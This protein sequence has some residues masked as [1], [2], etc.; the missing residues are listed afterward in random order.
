M[1]HNEFLPFSAESVRQNA[2]LS[3]SQPRILLGGLPKAYALTDTQI[4]NLFSS[5]E[6][7]TTSDKSTQAPFDKAEALRAG[8]SVCAGGLQQSRWEMPHILEACNSLAQ[9][10][11]AEA[12]FAALHITPAHSWGSGEHADMG[13]T[14]IG[15]LKG[16]KTWHLRK[17]VADSFTDFLE[18]RT[19]DDYYNGE[20]EAPPFVTLRP[21]DVLFVPSGWRHAATAQ[22]ERSA[23]ISYGGPYPG[24]ELGPIYNQD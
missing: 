21:G 20:H 3:T 6:H 7:F 15:Q 2:D 4:L 23:H 13:W 17:P 19:S 8:K 16:A 14:L 18:R 11:G 12:V 22:D 5:P 9:A 1:S 24:T 10:V